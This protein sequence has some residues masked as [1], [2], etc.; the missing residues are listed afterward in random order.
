MKR[1]PAERLI[2]GR[3]GDFFC[4]VFV[5]GLVVPGEGWILRNHHLAL[6]KTSKGI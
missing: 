4:F 2:W 6:D 3:V 1:R 5:V